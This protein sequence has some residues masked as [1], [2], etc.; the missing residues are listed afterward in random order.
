MPNTV[1]IVEPG[2]RETLDER[3]LDR[4]RDRSGL[5]LQAVARPDLDDGDR[6]WHCHPALHPMEILY[7]IC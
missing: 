5:I 3:D 1:T 7:G 2:R 4:R 6:V